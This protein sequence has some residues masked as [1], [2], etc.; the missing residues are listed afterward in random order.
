MSQQA[1]DIE[2]FRCSFHTDR[3]AVTA[4]TP[5]AWMPADSRFHRIQDDV[6]RHLY[7]LLLVLDPLVAEAIAEQMRNAP[8]LQAR[9][10]REAPV[11]HASRWTARIPTA[12]RAGGNDSE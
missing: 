5:L 8:V 9:P 2:P 3:R 7:E 1:G 11:A 12:R 10:P 6:T 4:P